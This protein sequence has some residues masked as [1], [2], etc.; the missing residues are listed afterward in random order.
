MSKMMNR[1]GAL[2]AAALSTA[3]VL[4]TPAIARP[5]W[6]GDGMATSVVGSIRTAMLPDHLAALSQPDLIMPSGTPAPAPSAL[7]SPVVANFL[8]FKGR[9]VLIGT[10]SGGRLGPRSQLL[11]GIAA[12]G[13]SA[14]D[15]HLILLTHLHPEHVGGLISANGTPVFTNATV[16]SCRTEWRWWNT[17]D[18]PAGLPDRYLPFVELARA[19]TR[20]YQQAGR[21]V[22]FS[23]TEVVAEGITGFPALGHTA[24]HSL[25]LLEDGGA[26]VLTLGDLVH[27]AALQIANPDI[28]THLD[29]DPALAA[30]TRR[31]VLADAADRKHAVVGNHIAAPGVSRVVRKG[32]SFE[33]A[34]A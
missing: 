2:R 33:L 9:N 3:A 25:Y 31:S 10:G 24:G 5:S 8:H 17:N 21:L 11:D 32:P 15:I 19:A 13:L 6:S 14:V 26:S 28:S 4:L 29:I 22:T 20:P 18:R 12:L 16:V 27:A 1:R 34:T 23:G 7:A 30:R